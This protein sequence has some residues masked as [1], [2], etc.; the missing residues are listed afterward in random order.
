M[1]RTSLNKSIQTKRFEEGDILML[2]DELYIFSRV[3]TIGCGQFAA[4]NLVNGNRYA[5]SKDFDA[6]IEH[7][8]NSGF[9]NLGSCNISIT[10]IA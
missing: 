9:I 3:G 5:D 2:D 7:L 8:K 1:N 10:P 6:A 4:I